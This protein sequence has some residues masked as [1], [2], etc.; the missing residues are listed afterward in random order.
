MNA[1]S[2]NLKDLKIDKSWT[3]FLDRDGVI[4]RRLEDDYVKHWIEFEFLDETLKGLKTLNSLFG[5]IV[6]VTNQ[7]GIGKRLYTHEDLELIHRNMVYEITYHGGRIDK[8]YFSPHLAAE[9]HPT[10]KPGIG[11]ALQAKTD[12]PAIDFKKSIMVGDSE[13]DM[14]FGKSAGMFTVFIG[15]KE[16]V[17]ADFVFSSLFDFSNAL[18]N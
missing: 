5:H 9:N 10:R 13:S 6:V 15:E 14:L 18:S 1:L 7:Q 12:F 4:N 17:H 8:V 11:M 16:N 2:M 3:L